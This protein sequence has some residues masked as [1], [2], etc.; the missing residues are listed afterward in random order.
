MK[1]EL[2]SIFSKFISVIIPLFKNKVYILIINIKHPS[3]SKTG[4]QTK[5]KDNKGTYNLT[6]INNCYCLGKCFLPKWVLATF[7]KRLY[8]IY[9]SQRYTRFV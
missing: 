6:H 3:Y 4:K 8:I 5:K 2:P 7:G 1:Y 9:G